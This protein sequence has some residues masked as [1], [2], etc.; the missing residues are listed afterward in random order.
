MPIAGLLFLLLVPIAGLFGTAE[1]GG[2]PFV[3]LL[4]FFGATGGVC[5]PRHG[6]AAII[7]DGSGWFEPVSDLDLQKRVM[8]ISHRAA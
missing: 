5:S 8:N 2:F 6:K 4:A 7:L 1:H 3:L